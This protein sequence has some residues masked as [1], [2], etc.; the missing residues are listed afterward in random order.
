MKRPESY[1]RIPRCRGCG[2]RMTLDGLPPPGSKLARCQVSKWVEDKY[3][4]KHERGKQPRCYPGRGGCNGYHFPHRRG[5]GWCDHNPNLTAEQLRD[6]YEGGVH[7][8]RR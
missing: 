7:S 2:R 4:A 1:A 3:R 8:S 5:S 6:R